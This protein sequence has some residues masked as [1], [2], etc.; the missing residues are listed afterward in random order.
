MDIKTVYMNQTT[1]ECLKKKKVHACT[2]Y[3]NNI[4][5]NMKIHFFR[6]YLVQI[7]RRYFCGLTERSNNS[8]VELDIHSKYSNII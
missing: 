8:N 2:F 1:S 5:N 7:C 4:E 6:V 3:V